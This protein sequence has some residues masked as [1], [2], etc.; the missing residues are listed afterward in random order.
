MMFDLERWLNFCYLVIHNCFPSFDDTS[1]I[2]HLYAITLRM[3]SPSL[4]KKEQLVEYR[5][6]QVILCHQ[7]LFHVQTLC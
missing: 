3:Y 7:I 6:N 4:L 1:Y 2:L 5:H